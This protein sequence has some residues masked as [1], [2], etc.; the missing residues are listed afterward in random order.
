MN[1]MLLSKTLLF[2][3]GAAFGSVITWKIVK[4]KY[5][6]LA[7]EEIESVREVYAKKK[8]YVSSDSVTEEE[9]ED[10][11]DHD[12]V[13]ECKQWCK[14]L[15]YTSDDD[16]RAV[17]DTA[18]DADNED[19]DEDN[20]GSNPYVISPEEL[21]DCDYPVVTLRY[22]EDGVLTNNR[23]KIISNVDELIGEDSLTHFGEYEEDSV[24]VRNDEMGVDYEI[25]MDYRAYAETKE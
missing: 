6:K 23:G 16:E 18:E 24:F 12:L 2:I 7:Q 19:E 25:L 4:T 14:D 13:N 15:G 11:D 8:E 5:E 1:K 17:E 22:F 10:S 3:S 9:Q 21:G 20:Y